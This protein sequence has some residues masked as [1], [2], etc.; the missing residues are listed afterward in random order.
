MSSERRPVVHI[1]TTHSPR[2]NRIFR[3]ECTGLA[4]AGY[5]VTL[6]APGSVDYFENSV[7]ILSI[8]AFESRLK[9]M[10]IGPLRVAARIRALRPAVVHA[11]DPELIPVL[12]A[13][14]LASRR[15][16][17]IYDAHEDL[18]GQ[19]LSKQ[20]IPKIV[21]P[22]VRFFAMGLCRVAGLVS[23]LV[24][25]ATPSIQITF[26][27]G[28]TIL[29]QNFPWLADFSE[30]PR[31]QPKYSASYVGGLNEIRGGLQ[32][33]KAFSDSGKTAISCIAA[34][35]VSEAV[36][37]GLSGVETIHHV[38]NVTAEEVPAVIGDGLVGIVCFLPAPNHLES[39]PTKM[40][41]YMAAGRAVVCSDFPL[42]RR[43]I[44]EHKCGVLVDPLDPVAIRN[45]VTD[46]AEDP[47]SALAMGR[48]ARLAFENHFTFD[49]EL[50][51][52]I[53]AYSMLIG[54]KESEPIG[55]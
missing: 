48:R 24:V 16:R 53:R 21:R 43:L 50:P 31:S 17:I 34:G 44:D 38:G 32:L 14:R 20:Y 22:L 33:V 13:I 36:A 9:R 10:I 12:V 15:V 3:K 41:E 47:D 1:T 54:G 55:G 49:V 37:E 39:Q 52:L 18:P 28:K 25:C 19:V 4:S 29:V 51:R 7:Q 35:S 5:E 11:H 46:A 30:L 2:D 40:F 42:W 6:I 26:P 23:D 8:G 45:A 27:V